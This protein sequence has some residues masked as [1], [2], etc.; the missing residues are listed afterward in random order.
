MAVPI[1]SRYRGEPVYPA[2]D[3]AGVARPTVAIRRHSPP[4]G[5]PDY[6]HVV[7]GAEDMEYLSWRF[8][9]DSETWWRI[10]DANPVVFPLDLRPGEHLAVP[11][12]D[13]AGRIDRVR[14][15]S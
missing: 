1:S 3:A 13:Q 12:T 2:P 8:Y 10:A 15:F 11:T 4:P 14:R 5:P 7:T 6:R 9:G